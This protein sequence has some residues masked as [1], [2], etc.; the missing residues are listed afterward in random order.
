MYIQLSEPKWQDPD[1]VSLATSSLDFL[2]MAKINGLP[3]LVRLSLSETL[4][5]RL[6]SFHLII[7]I[8]C[9][10]N[11]KGSTFVNTSSLASRRLLKC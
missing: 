2:N 4:F 9:R 1:G 8:L 3:V 6:P 7:I 5:C 10:H 11:V